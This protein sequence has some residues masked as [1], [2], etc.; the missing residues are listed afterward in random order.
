MVTEYPAGWPAVGLAVVGAE[1][2]VKADR[3]VDHP[4]VDRPVANRPP[5]GRCANQNLT[6]LKVDT[7]GAFGR[8]L[9]QPGAQHGAGVE[10]L[11]VADELG[12]GLVSPVNE[13]HEP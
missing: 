12:P 2:V 7:V 6:A 10:W 3:A 4:P 11:S 13:R 9:V 1:A 8:P 5:V